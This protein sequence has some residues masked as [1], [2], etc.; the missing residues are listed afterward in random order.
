MHCLR[1]GELI[2]KNFFC[3]FL[4]IQCNRQHLPNF[5][6]RT[7]MAD[8]NYL[9]DD[10]SLLPSRK[11]TLALIKRKEMI[12][13]AT[14]N[15][16]QVGV[17]LIMQMGI[18]KTMVALAT[19]W[20]IDRDDRE[21]PTLILCKKISESLWTDELTKWLKPTEKGRVKFECLTSSGNRTLNSENAVTVDYVITTYS[22]LVTVHGSLKES[23]QAQRCQEAFGSGCLYSI[24][25]T[26]IICDESQYFKNPKS[27]R[28][29]AVNDLHSKRRLCLSRSPMM[30]VVDDIKTQLD[31][32][33]YRHRF[34]DDENVLVSAVD[35]IIV[36]HQ[37]G[38]YSS[39]CS[40]ARD[41]GRCSQHT[42]EGGVG[43]ASPPEK[44]EEEDLR[45]LKK[46]ICK[47]IICKIG[48]S[49]LCWYSRY[50]QCKCCQGFIPKCFNFYK[51]II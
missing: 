5:G 28:F 36:I 22:H 23:C 25:R 4:A 49:S 34:E 41:R 13:M 24:K 38:D 19:R 18:G 20:E 42:H 10:V 44:R 14:G 7:D 35:W 9:A 39:T 1:T 46:I 8:S 47:V 26:R 40:S 17:V 16:S 2:F 48:N 33:G 32:C 27:K 12:Q 43:L 11:D 3:V 29:A 30:N 6:D 21:K 15:T 45:I 50:S 37:E 31:F 51:S